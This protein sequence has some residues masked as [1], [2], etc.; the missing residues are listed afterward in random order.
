VLPSKYP[1]TV[2]A[3]FPVLTGTTFGPS[4]PGVINLVSGQTNGVIATLNGTGDEVSGGGDGSLTLIGDADPLR[5]Q[6]HQTGV[7]CLLFRRVAMIL[8]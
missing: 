5:K 1:I 7:E 3:L 4:S 6:V 8:I 2:L